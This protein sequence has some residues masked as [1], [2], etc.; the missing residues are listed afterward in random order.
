MPLHQFLPTPRH[1][2]D[3]LADVR[4]ALFQLGP[5][6][7]SQAL[8]SQNLSLGALLFIELGLASM[9]LPIGHGMQTSRG[10]WSH[11]GD[12]GLAGREPE[13]RDTARPETAAPLFA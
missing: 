4:R 9:I 13:P 3:H 8:W 7:T 5:V 2:L 6:L 12:A 10:G 1:G 11:H